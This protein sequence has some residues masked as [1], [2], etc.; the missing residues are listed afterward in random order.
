MIPGTQVYQLPR[1]PPVD[2]LTIS[3]LLTVRTEA[4]TRI[5]VSDGGVF[6][7]GENPTVYHNI[8]LQGGKSSY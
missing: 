4:P 3:L 2:T 6:V 1:A 8:Y 5:E 7:A